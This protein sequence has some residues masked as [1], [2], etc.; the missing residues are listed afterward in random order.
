MKNAWMVRAGGTGGLFDDFKENGYVSIGW[1]EIGEISKSDTRESL[2]L[3]ILEPMILADV[4]IWLV[5][6]KQ[7][8]DLIQS[9]QTM[10]Q[11]IFNQSIGRKKFPETL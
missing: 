2:K 1:G 8:I 3:K 9:G 5:Q 10:T 4:F 6:R 11:R 7:I